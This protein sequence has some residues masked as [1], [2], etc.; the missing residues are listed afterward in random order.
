MLRLLFCY[1]AA[2]AKHRERLDKHLSV[3][4]S[5]FLTQ[6]P[7]QVELGGDITAQ[8]ETWL[9]TTDAL[10]LLLSPDF[11]KDSACT[12]LRERARARRVQIVPILVR[13]FA[14]EATEFAKVQVLPAGV[15][16]VSAFSDQDKAWKLVTEALLSLPSSK[17]PAALKARAQLPEPP[18][19]SHYFSGREAALKTLNDRFRAAEQEGVSHV[20]VV[21]GLGGIGKSQLAW[22]YAFLYRDHYQV[23]LHL[24]GSSDV[25]LR[26]DLATLAAQLRLQEEPAADAA[27]HWLSEQRGLLVIVD[28]ADDLNALPALRQLCS[29]LKAG[30]L[31]VTTRQDSDEDLGSAPE[32]RL[33]EWSTAE[34]LAF[35]RERCE[36]P[37][38][39]S[40]QLEELATELDN[41]PLALEQ[42]GAHISRLR[43]PVTDYLKSLQQRGLDFLRPNSAYPVSVARTWDLNIQRVR[44]EKPAAAAL[45]E[46]VA[47]LAPD[48]IPQFLFLEGSAA[49]GPALQEAL[50]DA[51]RDPVLFDELLEPLLR[52]SLLTRDPTAQTIGLNRLVQEVIRG[53]L[54]EAAQRTWA[55]RLVRALAQLFPEVDYSTEKR[56]RLLLTHALSCAEWITRWDLR[57]AEAGRLLWRVGHLLLEQAQPVQ[58]QPLLDRALTLFEALEQQDAVVE[59]LNLLGWSHYSAGRYAEAEP[60][61]RRAL[62]LA[63]PRGEPKALASVLNNLGLLEG[64]LGHFAAAEDLHRRALGLRE[65]ALGP[66]LPLGPAHS[67]VAQSLNNLGLVAKEMGRYADAEQR[68]QR[69]LEIRRVVH[70][71]VHPLVAVV[72]HNLAALYQ[73]QGRY[74]DAEPL[75]QKAL[76]IREETL[77]AT[78]T[79]IANSLNGLA[80]I[81]QKQGRYADAVPLLE[82]ALELHKQALRQEHPMVAE[83]LSN[84]AVSYQ[85]LNKDA[86]AAPLLLRA[87]GIIDK[88]GS[89][90][91]LAVA[92]CLV[93]LA[94]AERRAGHLEQA[95]AR[96]LRAL[97]IQERAQPH[98]DPALA[99]IQAQLTE[100]RQLRVQT[101]AAPG[102]LPG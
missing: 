20:Q 87:L 51:L 56:C 4:P 93:N 89:A 95:E 14:I 59:V 85:H 30:H 45:M 99:S 84:L 40:D 83:N 58:A 28:S 25:A 101:A 6:D 16:P 77:H 66:E 50:A 88:A 34:A 72:L 33:D 102:L 52:Y 67:L 12:Q 54:D 65:A 79:S 49:L 74:A 97:S 81:Y 13:N 47:F 78:H 26:K 21:S 31:L 10:L 27:L 48:A 53:G 91:T 43:T 92:R 46:C 15:T 44:D 32:L 98:D 80:V 29:A 41:L 17:D 35:L 96:L 71:A 42:A 24:D 1:A 9:D 22:A 7:Q 69:A 70:G 64:D 23:R 62:T 55:E 37:Q 5:S 63:E 75:A 36:R 8:V 61:Y 68:Y 100:V 86:L 60:L 57:S 11:F 90:E 82:R 94:T 2:D 38:G 3:S 18:Q 76:K 19:Q 73:V 39:E